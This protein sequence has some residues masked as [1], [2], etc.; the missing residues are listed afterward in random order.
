MSSLALARK[1]RPQG[2]D[3]VVGQETT[4][5][6]LRNA[7]AQ[8]RLHHAY[9]FTGPRGIG[10]TT[11]ARIFA[12]AL[13]CQK[14]DS[15]AADPCNECVSCK[16][17]TEGRSLSVQEI[18]GASNTSVEDVRDL[19]EKIRYLPPGGRYKIY[20]IDEVHMLSTAAFNALLKTLEEPPPHAL[21]LFATTDAQKMPATVLSRVIR[22]DLKPILRG[23]IVQQL[24][25]ILAAEGVPAEGDALFLIA[26]EAE[27]GLRDA[28]SLL[29]QVISFSGGKV[30]L[31]G[32]EEVVGV[33]TQGFV[34]ELI[35]AVLGKDSAAALGALEKAFQAGLDA[36][37]LG[38]DLLEAF[39]HLLVAQVSQDPSLF[40]LPK[41]EIGELAVLAKSAAPAQLD[42]LFRMVQKGVTDLLRAPLPRVVFDVLVL[43]LASAEDLVPLEDI[44][45]GLKGG[46]PISAATPR[47]ATDAGH[48]PKAGGGGSTRSAD[49]AKGA[50]RSNPDWPGFIAFLK[51]K[52]VRLASLVEQGAVSSLG[53]GE[54]AEIRLRF[55]QKSAM[56]VELLKDPDRDGALAGFLKEYFGRSLRPV[57]ESDAPAA[58]AQNG[59][60]LVDDAIS[61]FEPADVR[62]GK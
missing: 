28:L 53:N 14:T 46:A 45:A 33:S 1:Y 43:R 59:G 49:S 7:L 47:P 62:R 12:K 25:R 8:K 38:L 31:P 21:F 24:E 26:R 20:I 39:R 30:T 37:R 17:I 56:N 54:G 22:F 5:Q 34:R 4:V 3:A 18:D 50:P 16:E 27:G 11:L 58:S 48:P 10:K 6:I 40:D 35:R 61:I 51:T 42:R 13:N 23:A 60:S 15:P 36:K 32:V 57:Y 41:E 55:P 29:D 9:L 19:R 2:F 52:S 44:L